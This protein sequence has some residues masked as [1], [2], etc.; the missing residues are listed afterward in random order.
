MR[1]LS[2]TDFVDIVSK[3]GTPKATKVRQVKERPDY[4]PSID[5]YKN[6][7]DAIVQ[8]SRGDFGENSLDDIIT[9]TSPK[10][11]ENYTVIK[12]GFSKWRGKKEL[13]W[14]DPPSRLYENSGISVSV[15]PELGLIINGTSHLVKLYFKPEELTKNRVD[16]ITY[17][18]TTCLKEYTPPNTTMSILDL[19]QSKLIT[20]PT[21]SD[22]LATLINAE[23]AYIATIWDSLQ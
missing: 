22:I 12:N 14:F 13:V 19:R 1:R 4:S 7:R 8:L 10:K 17:L 23:L 11:R 5:Y 3:S 2:L 15:N 21:P 18:M 6:M 9:N 16:I 20:E